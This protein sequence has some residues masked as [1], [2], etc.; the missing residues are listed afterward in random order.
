M[1][2]FRYGG[3]KL[4]VG[5]TQQKLTVMASR[6]ADVTTLH[7]AAEKCLVEAKEC[8]DRTDGQ[9]H[10]PQP[11]RKL[12]KYAHR[13][14]LTDED[15]IDP[16]DLESIEIIVGL[17]RTGL[18]SDVT[19]KTGAMDVRGAV[20][21]RRT[22]GAPSPNVKPY[23]N[24][25]LDLDD[26]RFWRTGAIHLEDQRLL[27]GRLGVK[28]LIHEASHKYAGTCDY[29]YF[30][31]NGITPRGTF[32]QKHLALMNADSYGWFVIQVGSKW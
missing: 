29:C 19:I 6:F 11:S 13:Y 23:H 31:D 1:T 12:L 4:S 25:V 30:R 21:Q 3:H 14:F 5:G 24:A 8:L 20:N 28:T 17:I 18:Q 2:R 15:A 10:N 32:S 22:A 16:D 7:A 26:T 27:S 9:L